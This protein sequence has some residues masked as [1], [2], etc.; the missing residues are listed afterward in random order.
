MAVFW[1]AGCGWGCDWDCDW[2]CDCGCAGFRLGRGFACGCFKH[3]CRTHSPRLLAQAPVALVVHLKRFSSPRGGVPTKINKHI[4]FPATLD[5]TP[6]MVDGGGDGA[7]PVLYDLIGVVVHTGTGVGSGHYPCCVKPS[8]GTWF[9]YDDAVVRSVP[10]GA[11]LAEQAYILVYNQRFPNVVVAAA[12]PVDGE[13]R[14]VQWG[15]RGASRSPWQR[16][17]RERCCIGCLSMPFA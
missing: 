17:G 13:V 4:T 1:C 2:G 8:I 15:G 12:A 16:F 11:V 3:L 7:P 14:E 5:A 9:M 6:Y 10:V